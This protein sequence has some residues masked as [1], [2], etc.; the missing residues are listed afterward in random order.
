VV[1][2]RLWIT[3]IGF[4]FFSTVYA[5][6]FLD[7]GPPPKQHFQ[8]A[9]PPAGA[10]QGNKTVEPFPGEPQAPQGPSAPT[11]QQPSPPQPML[12]PGPPEIPNIV[13]PPGDAERQQQKLQQQVKELVEQQQQQQVQLEEFGGLIANL[14]QQITQ[15]ATSFQILQVKMSRQKTPHNAFLRRL[16][17]VDV[18][19]SS[20]I[21][22]IMLVA[23]MLLSLIVG[24]MLRGRRQVP[25]H[26]VASTSSEK[27]ARSRSHSKSK[28]KAQPAAEDA[29][30]DDTASEYDFMGSSEAIP[31]KLDL[32]RAYIAMEDYVAAK[33]TLKEIA[34]EGNAQQQQEAKDLL[35][36]IPDQHEK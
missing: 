33:R 20:E 24:A 13:T 32:A 22:L 12:P 29:P 11:I 31:A 6:G 18:S 9:N 1:V 4:A 23:L 35:E 7:Q 10:N 17:K 8:Q 16:H 15:I 27:T 2:K 19:L 36:S 25:Q 5:Q 26:K 21:K 28:S 30:L 14:Q 34:A 3:L